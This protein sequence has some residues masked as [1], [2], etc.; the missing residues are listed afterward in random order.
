MIA[1]AIANDPRLLIA[2]EPTTALDVTI[3]A[4]VLELL[5]DLQREHRM[6][7]VFITHSLPVVS[8]I[9]DRVLVM[10]AGELVEQGTTREIFASPLH[11]YTA[12]LLA[13]CATQGR[14]VA[15]R[16]SR[17]RAVAACDAAGLRLRATLP[18]ATGN[19]RTAAPTVGRGR[20]GR[21]T[22]CLR[23][24]ELA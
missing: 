16:H 21:T 15:G 1:M 24:R 17:H 4:Q 3:Q 13:Q 7:L 10:Y 18:H 12:A 20:A 23:W 5:A 2:D 9:A 22:R 8:E 11:P 19:L 14:R 6:G